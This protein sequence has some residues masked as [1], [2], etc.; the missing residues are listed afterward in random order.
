M[1]QG[2]SLDKRHRS[3]CQLTSPSGEEW[4]QTRGK[5]RQPRVV[6]MLSQGCHY[7]AV[8]LRSVVSFLSEFPKNCSVVQDCCEDTGEIRSGLRMKEP[9][10]RS[11]AA[12]LSQASPSLAWCSYSTRSHLESLLRDKLT[13]L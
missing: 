2:G 10:M 9:C 3:H 8:G 5:G 4:A 12:P 13:V 11:A 1:K 6:G 7:L